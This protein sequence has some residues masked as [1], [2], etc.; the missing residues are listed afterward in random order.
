MFETQLEPCTFLDD[1]DDEDTLVDVHLWEPDVRLLEAAS[2]EF[3]TPI[4]TLS[5]LPTPIHP[6]RL[7]K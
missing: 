2:D 3:P 4:I 6:K 5:D 1:L 7:W